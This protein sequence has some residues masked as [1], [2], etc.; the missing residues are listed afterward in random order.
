MPC[1][2]HQCGTLISI[3]R[4]YFNAFAMVY[5]CLRIRNRRDILNF[6]FFF[7]CVKSRLLK[8]LT[9]DQNLIKVLKSN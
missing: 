9:Q 7:V 8:E 6:S 3:D 2:Q 4:K 5:G 1:E